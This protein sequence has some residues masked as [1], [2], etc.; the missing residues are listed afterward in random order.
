MSEEIINKIEKKGYKDKEMVWNTYN[1]LKNSL[2]ETKNTI[3]MLP[4]LLIAFSTLLRFL[5]VKTELMMIAIGFLGL[6]IEVDALYYYIR[7][8]NFIKRVRNII[9]EDPMNIDKE[10]ILEFLP[11]LLMAIIAWI[12][13]IVIAFY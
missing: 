11:Y 10:D 1:D 6:I 4:N 8:K 7:A 9:I 3:Y 12:V 13:F 5:G 2:R